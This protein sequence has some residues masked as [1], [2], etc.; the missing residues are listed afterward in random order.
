QMKIR[1]ASC[2]LTR[3]RE[4]KSVRRWFASSHRHLLSL[5][6]ESACDADAEFQNEMVQ[7]GPVRAL[8]STDQLYSRFDGSRRTQVEAAGLSMTSTVPR[9]TL[10][11][12]TKSNRWRMRGSRPQAHRHAHQSRRGHAPRGRYARRLPCRP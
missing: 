1:G 4:W 7:P 2:I 8:L 12:W 11:T 9:R 6:R 5:R 10:V 3:I